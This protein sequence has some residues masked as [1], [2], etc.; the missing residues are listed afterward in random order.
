MF[1]T[2]FKFINVQLHFTM[3]KKAASVSN[4]VRK[5]DIKQFDPLATPSPKKSE[6]SRTRLPA[7][8]G[9]GIPFR[10]LD[11]NM[12]NPSTKCSSRQQIGRFRISHS[13]KH[14][15]PGKNSPTFE[16]DITTGDEFLDLL[17]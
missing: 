9:N 15:D 5:E 4:S 12:G 10:E 8:S 7:S 6:F 14:A 11:M 2:C 17:F 16:I 1:V 13:V 3:M